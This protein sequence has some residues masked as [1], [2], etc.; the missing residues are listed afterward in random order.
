MTKDVIS[1]KSF[2]KYLYGIMMSSDMQELGYATVTLTEHQLD[3]VMMHLQP[4]VL[5]EY[6]EDVWY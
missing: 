4:I 5:G 6:Q 3:F 1:Y 2:Y